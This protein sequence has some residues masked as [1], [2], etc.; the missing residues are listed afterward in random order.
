MSQGAPAGR[1]PPLPGA[2]GT[3][4]PFAAPPG[5]SRS[6][7]GPGGIPKGEG[8]ADLGAIKRSWRRLIR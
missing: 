4:S 8:G 2:A 1:A 6:P 5:L 3:G 7:G